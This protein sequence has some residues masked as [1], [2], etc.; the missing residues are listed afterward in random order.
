MNKEFKFLNIIKNTLDSPNFLGDDCAFLKKQKITI[1]TDA[2]IENIHFSR[3]Y[4]TDEEIGKKSLLVNI[5]DILASGA[6]PKYALISL[7]GKLDNN[8]I[9]NFYK[10]INAIA[11]EYKIKIIGGDLTS[12]EKLSIA[13]TIIGDTKKRKISSR[14]NA[15]E[16]YIIATVGEFG[17]SAEGLKCLQ[18]NIKNEYFIKIHKSPKL[19]PK[20]SEAIAKKTTGPYAMMDSSDGLFDCLYQISKQSNVKISV[21]YNKIPKK[22]NDKNLVLYG[23]EDYSLVVA[24]SEK[25]FKKIKGLTKI[26]YCS[27]GQ[28]VYIDNKLTEYK[29]FNHFE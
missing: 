6:K 9:K 11:K 8:F 26:G 24:L 1:S 10:G 21:E 25:D 16:N 7:S 17:S 13:V 28:G 27:K 4:M 20:I 29:G 22:T 5:S 12:G 3:N 14:K 18:N 19:Y 15:K 2:L 23:G